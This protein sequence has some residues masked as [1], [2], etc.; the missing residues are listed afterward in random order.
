[1]LTLSRAIVVEGKYDRAK[2]ASLIQAPILQTDGFGIFRDASLRALIRRYAVTC[3]IIVLTDSDSAG[4]LIRGHVAS[5]AG[6][7]ADIVNLYIPKICGKER[8]KTKASKEGLLG[9]EGMTQDALFK[10]FERYA[11]AEEQEK[12]PLTRMELYEWG[13]F[14]TDEAASRRQAL[15]EECQL[16]KDLNVHQLLDALNFFYGKEE[17][18]LLCMRLFSGK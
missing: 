12:E 15:L 9:V 11:L 1:M 3:G 2:L 17:F 6:E 4:R 16:P 8:R 18:E 13:L 7:G 5:I 10:L 14:G